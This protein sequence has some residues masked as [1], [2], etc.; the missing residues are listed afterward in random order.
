MKKYT[1][2]Y[3]SHL[4]LAINKRESKGKNKN[5]VGKDGENERKGNGESDTELGF[6]LKLST[7]QNFTH[8]PTTK[9][10]TSCSSC[11]QHRRRNR[12]KGGWRLGLAF[13]Y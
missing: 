1:K 9:I 11:Q 8:M 12:G 2:A 10:K 5:K 13:P 4:L 7:K 6:F 3:R